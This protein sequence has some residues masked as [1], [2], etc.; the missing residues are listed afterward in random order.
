MSSTKSDVFEEKVSFSNF[1][2]SNSLDPRLIKSCLKLGYTSPTLV[3][4]TAIP[5]ALAGRDLL[6]RART[7][8]GKTAAYGLGATIYTD[9]WVMEAILKKAHQQKLEMTQ[10]GNLFR[11]EQI[12][13]SA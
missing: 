11:Q 5:L 13:P 3:Q 6:V 4:A 12:T 1:A 9:N 2:N 7:G 10:T 8:S